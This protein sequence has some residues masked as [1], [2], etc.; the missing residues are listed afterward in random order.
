MQ[1]IKAIPHTISQ[2][3]GIRKSSIMEA[4]NLNIP[5]KHSAIFAN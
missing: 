4:Q 1:E 2:K 5:A 3:I